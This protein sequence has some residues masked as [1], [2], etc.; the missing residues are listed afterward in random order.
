MSARLTNLEIRQNELDGN[1][2]DMLDTTHANNQALIDIKTMFSELLGKLKEQASPFS[3]PMSTC[4][5]AQIDSHVVM[6]KEKSTM[7][8]VN[9]LNNE[10]AHSLLKGNTI[11]LGCVGGSSSFKPHTATTPYEKLG[12][13]ILHQ[14]S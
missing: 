7:H 1:F 8:D 6:Q 5:E 4:E 3:K 2:C 13:K 12:Q 11:L 9:L 14:L 10:S